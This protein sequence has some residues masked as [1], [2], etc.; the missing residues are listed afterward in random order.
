MLLAAALFL[1]LVAATFSWVTVFHG[2]VVWHVDAVALQA[3][4]LELAHPV[5][6]G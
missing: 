6:G 4:W 1:F 2:Y 3:R 5:L